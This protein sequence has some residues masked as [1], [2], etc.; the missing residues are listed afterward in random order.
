MCQEVFTVPSIKEYLQARPAFYH[1]YFQ[2]YC[3][4][5]VVEPRNLSRL[6][7]DEAIEDP[8]A[9]PHIQFKTPQK[10]HNKHHQQENNSSPNYKQIYCDFESPSKLLNL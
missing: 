4:Q 2:K 9:L 3:M 5:S 8:Y 7:E 1:Q 6:Y 10:N